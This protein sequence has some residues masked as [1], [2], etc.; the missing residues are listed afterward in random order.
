MPPGLRDFSTASQDAT[1]I[2]TKPLSWRDIL[3]IHPAAELFPPLLPD[4][5]R[6]LGEDISAN[7]LTSQI[8]I[9]ID[10]H[11]ASWLLD[12]RSRL[13]AMEL[14]GIP[15]QLYKNR[16]DHWDLDSSEIFLPDPILRIESPAN[17]YNYV[18]SANIHRRH[19]TAEQ[20]RDLI[21]KLLKADPSKSDRQIAET[22]KASP[23]TVGTVRAKMEAKGEVSKLDTRTDRKGIEQPARKPPNRVR[24]MIYR[25]M[26]LDDVTVDAL[27]GTSLDSAAEMDALVF[28]NRGAQP[29]N[30][31]DVV[32]QL[33]A[34]AIAGKVVSAIEEKN[35]PPPHLDHPESKSEGKSGG[36]GGVANDAEDVKRSADAETTGLESEIKE[37][38]AAQSADDDPS[39]SEWKPKCLAH[40]PVATRLEMLVGLLEEGL[41]PIKKLALRL[42][43]NASLKRQSQLEGLQAQVGAI[44]DWM[45]IV[46]DEVGE[47]RRV[48]IAQHHDSR[49]NT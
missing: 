12:G 44:F 23:T 48:L 40:L 45:N 13:D 30:H 4:G 7:G 32:A 20:R 33:V 36:E 8:A 37:A 16:Y 39:E 46:K 42:P 9:Y 35:K 41:T 10:E 22:V 1:R 19:L 6:A 17:P 31:T 28:L 11:K 18:T 2:A 34:D 27:K 3:P 24:P 47:I 25:R 38:K 15:F 14:V 21:V 49:R 26:E 29:G 5:L 43:A